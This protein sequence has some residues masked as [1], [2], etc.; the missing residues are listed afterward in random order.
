M[1]EVNFHSINIFEYLKSKINLIISRIKFCNNSFITEKVRPIYPSI[2]KSFEKDFTEDVAILMQGP[3]LEKYK[4][5]EETL[6]LYRKNFPYSKIILSTWDSEKYKTDILKELNIE[7]LFSNNKNIY[8]GIQNVN[9]QIISTL[10]GINYIKEKGYKYTLKTRTDQRFGNK[11]LLSFLKL[12]SNAFPLDTKKVSD[13]KGRL[14]GMSFNT[15]MFK[16]YSLSDMFLFGETQDVY[17][18]WNCE[19]DLREFNNIE[20]LDLSTNRKFSLLR[21]CEIYYMT[22]FLKSKGVNLNWTLEQSW[23]ELVKRFL[24]VDSYSLDFFWPK[25]SYYEDRWSVN[26]NIK[27]MEFSFSKWLRINYGE[28]KSEEYILDI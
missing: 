13:Q 5:T 15:F 11:D 21:I 10:N 9:L 27:N 23:E 20:N 18:Y 8:P 26:N 28:I 6:R 25:Y 24:I 7:I 4:F 14:I 1:A 12:L 17:D 22:E 3:I 2:Y 19:L 16:M